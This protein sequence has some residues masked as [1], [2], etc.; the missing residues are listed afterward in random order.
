MRTRLQLFEGLDLDEEVFSVPVKPCENLNIL[1]QRLAIK[2][3]A[4]DSAGDEIPRAPIT[5]QPTAI[6]WEAALSFLECTTGGLPT[7]VRTSYRLV[8]RYSKF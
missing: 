5:E 8:G 2:P 6:A 3:R 4:S 1:Q 7:L